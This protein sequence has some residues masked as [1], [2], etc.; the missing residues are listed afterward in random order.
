M[1]SSQQPLIYFSSLGLE[2]VRCFGERRILELTDEE[3]RL[4]QW[5][6]LLGDNGVGKTTLL[7]C[8]AWMRP[9]PAFK[10]EDGKSDRKP[11][12]I[13]PA[14]ISEEN[15]VLDSL[16]RTGTDVTLELNATLS[17]GRRLGAKPNVQ[18]IETGIRLVGKN[19]QLQ[20]SELTT[21]DFPA[22][23]KNLA[24][25][26]LPIFA[27]GAARRMGIANL[28]KREFFDPL[29][30][31]F[32]TETELRNAEQTL[33]DLDYLALAAEKRHSR[34]YRKRLQKVKELLATIL[35]DVKDAEGIKIFG[36][37]VLGKPEEPSG[38]KFETPYGIV[39][40]SGLSLGYQTTLAWTLDLATRLYE[41]YPNSANP[42]AEPAIV[43]VDE[44][45]LHLHPYWQRRIIADLTQHFPKI[46]FIATAHSPLMVQA[47]TDA[48]L[49]VLREQDGQAMIENRPY[50]VESWRVDQILTSELFDLASARS[51]RIERLIA[52]RNALLDKL[53]RGS[54]EEARL[55]E[56]E[57][58]LENLPTAEHKDQEAM[59]LIRQAAELLKTQEPRKR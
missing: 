30:S 41:R 59:D 31:L 25:L 49:A 44:I 52:E 58:E 4:S 26:D 27:Y 43:L 56:L 11:D 12:T 16:L 7:Q 9:V 8:L 32:S 10:E 57:H 55:K 21:N 1:G 14:L 23:L 33:L 45:D 28:E 2:N 53:K 50:F 47:A 6:L 17:I 35:P 13:E 36:P 19:G 54:R 48:N 38:V 20:K 24:L 51:P 18:K 37:Q 42:L 22:G 29:A 39:P 5:T 40:L 15:R 3:G 34:R 46:Q